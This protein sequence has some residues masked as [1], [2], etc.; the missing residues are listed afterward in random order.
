MILDLICSTSFSATKKQKKSPQ[1][2]TIKSEVPELES[3]GKPTSKSKKASKQAPSK[4]S[5]VTI[6]VSH[7]TSLEIAKE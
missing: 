1:T 2:K 7:F 4:Q 6:P 3:E 5:E